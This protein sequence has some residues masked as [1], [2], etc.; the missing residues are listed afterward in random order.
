MQVNERLFFMGM[1]VL[2]LLMVIDRFATWLFNLVSAF[3]QIVGLYWS[4]IY[5][6]VEHTYGDWSSLI[7]LGAMIGA[8]GLH[9]ILKNW[10]SGQ[11]KAAIITAL[12]IHGAA[13]TNLFSNY[14]L[15]APTAQ[16]VFLWIMSLFVVPMLGIIG[17][18]SLVAV[19]CMLIYYG[20]KNTCRGIYIF[21]RSCIENIIA[22][23]MM[24]RAAFVW[25]ASFKTEKAESA[26]EDQQQQHQEQRREEKQREDPG[27]E[28]REDFDPSRFAGSRA[29]RGFETR[30]PMDA[31]LWAVIDDENAQDGDVEN[32]MRRIQ[33]NRAKRRAESNTG[34]RAATA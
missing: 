17:L 2:L 24:I 28:K 12:I 16:F 34:S 13:L 1:G 30:H 9:V 21:A 18:I 33:K 31:K 6:Y 5:G 29:P 3:F 14:E 4:Y 8:C 22:L 19:V 26:Q 10:R 20:T 7:V 23:V 32:A 11:M 27:K 25:A 15:A